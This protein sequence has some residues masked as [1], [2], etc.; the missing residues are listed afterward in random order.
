MPKIWFVFPTLNR[1]QTAR[2][3]A[4][5]KAGLDAGVIEISRMGSYPIPGWRSPEADRLADVVTLFDDLYFGQISTID[6]KERMEKELA[7]HKNSIDALAI[8]GWGNREA[9]VAHAWALRNQVP[10][11]LLSE[12]TEQDRSR[13]RIGEWVKRKLV[14]GFDSALV[15]G[16]EH[17]R[18]LQKLGFSVDRISFGYNAVDN[19]Y[20]VDGATSVRGNPAGHRHEL[21][22]DGPFFLCACRMV[23][24]KN[25]ALLLDAYSKYR[26]RCTGDGPENGAGHHGDASES[27]PA[28]NPWPLVI[29][30]DGPLR[31]S[32]LAQRSSLG[33]DHCVH[34][35]GVKNYDEMPSY[36]GLA[37]AFVLPS[38]S[39]PW[40][41][42]VNEAMA[43]GLPVLVSNRCGCCSEIVRDGVNGFTFRPD[44]PAQLAQ[45]MGE[46]SIS[47]DRANLMGQASLE[48]ISQWGPARFSDGLRRAFQQAR[49][50]Q[51]AKGSI[52]LQALLLMRLL[53]TSKAGLIK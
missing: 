12:S 46:V 4:C 32:L 16:G 51:S 6:L 40:G 19:Q 50:S 10:C 5:L 48:I 37:G 8:L 39:E 49:E 24:Q 28:A 26:Q 36:Y 14:A 3:K 18:Y 9:N 47:I 22:F 11:V 44:D 25:L 42:V 52:V 29:L 27:L 13:S 30:G 17:L 21:G 38:Q 45:L 33:L 15:G 20:F 41:L 31:E 35:P 53:A 2:F 23:S 43:S 7:K 1:Y 34:F